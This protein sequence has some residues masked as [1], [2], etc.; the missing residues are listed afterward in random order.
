MRVGLRG[1]SV[2]AIHGVKETFAGLHVF[3]SARLRMGAFAVWG[4]IRGVL[5]ARRNAQRIAAAW[6]ASHKSEAALWTLALGLAV[7]IGIAMA[8]L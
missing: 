6:W 7:A 3:P 5:P 8:W 1:I 4:S 2:V